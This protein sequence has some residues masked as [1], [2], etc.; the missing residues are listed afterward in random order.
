VLLRLDDRVSFPLDRQCGRSRGI[1][2]GVRDAFGHAVAGGRYSAMDHTRQVTIR[3]ARLADLAAIAAIQAASPE[4][5]HWNPADYLTHDCRVADVASCVAG[6]IV[7]REVAPGEREILN[8]AVDPA[9]RR[10]G[11]ARGLLRDALARAKG[12]WFLEVRASNSAAIRLYESA[13]FHC[14]G[15]RPKYYY[16]PSEDAIVMRFFS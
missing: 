16:E 7:T 13:G 5:A 1:L 14:A 8:L 15:R 12:A 2:A 3:P 10:T 6:F 11:I 4:A 9:E